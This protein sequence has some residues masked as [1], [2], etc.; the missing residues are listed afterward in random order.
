MVPRDV[1]RRQQVEWGKQMAARDATATFVL[2]LFQSEGARFNA[3]NVAAAAHR[4]GKVGGRR[5]RLDPRLERLAEACRG[6]AFTA[7]EVALVCWGFAKTGYPNSA[8]LFRELR[9]EDHVPSL[10]PHAVAMVAY[11]FSSSPHVSA[12]AVFDAIAAASENTLPRFSAR[13][14]AS[15]VWAFATARVPAPSLFDAVALEATRR[16]SDFAAQDLATLLWSF[17]SSTPPDV[18]SRAARHRC[19]ELIAQHCLQR[20]LEFKPK[21]LVRALW[22]LGCLGLTSV[23]SD[24]FTTDLSRASLADVPHADKARLHLAA[25]YVRL[26]VPALPVFD[27]EGSSSSERRTHVAATLAEAQLLS[28][29]TETNEEF[30]PDLVV[31]VLKDKLAVQVHGPEDYVR[32]ELTCAAHFRA[33]AL[34]RLGWDVRHVAPAEW[35][36]AVDRRLLLENKLT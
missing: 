17:N 25:L 36:A 28:L 23:F 5:V 10:K 26:E 29:E 18:D 6:A 3:R 20:R 7:H 9:V 1:S 21:D 14:L 8:E 11:A 32:D 35:D 24:L 4:I 19:F 2:F 27:T 22:A 15:V 34:H 16:L 31:V 30:L 13:D 12:T 33:L